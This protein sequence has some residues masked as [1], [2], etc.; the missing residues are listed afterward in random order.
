MLI[1]FGEE[2]LCAKE[3]Y[4]G[5][6]EVVAGAQIGFG[7]FEGG[8][9]D[10]F[11]DVEDPLCTERRTLGAD[12]AVAGM[13]Q[14]RADAEGDDLARRDRRQG[15]FDRGAKGGFIVDHMIRRK[16]QH[17]LVGIAAGEPVRGGSEGGRG[18][19]APR[20][21]DNQ[22]G[23]VARLLELIAN[24]KALVFGGDQERKAEGGARHARRSVLE[25]RGPAIETRQLLWKLCTTERPKPRSGAAAEDYGAN[26]GRCLCAR[27]RSEI[28]HTPP[29]RAVAEARRGSK[30]LQQSVSNWTRVQAGLQLYNDNRY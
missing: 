14:C 9:L 7:L 11:G 29:S 22:L 26:P 24:Q 8:L 21:E 2:I 17:D 20:L 5:V 3:E 23:W 4:P 6:P 13:R 15:A 25:Q 12:V 1:Q 18:I 27:S 16:H 19:A 10:E 28:G 30:V